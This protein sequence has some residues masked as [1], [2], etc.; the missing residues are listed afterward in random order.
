MLMRQNVNNDVILK[1]AYRTSAHVIAVCL[2]SQSAFEKHN[3]E[4]KA[5]K[6][7]RTSCIFQTNV[8]AMFDD[9]K[10]LLF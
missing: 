1:S 3:Q 6:P 8:S 10:T 5:Q 7:L 9:Q 2:P 4:K